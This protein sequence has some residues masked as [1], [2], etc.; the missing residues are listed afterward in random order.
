MNQCAPQRP[1]WRESSAAQCSSMPWSPRRTIDVAGGLDNGT[2]G[3]PG[4]PSAE[5]AC[6]PRQ[7]GGEGAAGVY[8][9]HDVRVGLRPCKRFLSGSRARTA[10]SPLRPVG[11]LRF[12]VDVEPDRYAAV[13]AV[14]SDHASHTRQAGGRDH[15]S[16]L[17]RRARDLARMVGQRAGGHLIS[18]GLNGKKVPVQ[19]LS[20]SA[21]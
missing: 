9:S 21:C 19:S 17:Q 2:L 13:P 1:P 18:G 12:P 11:G 10:R 15:V 16:L 5:L 14:A 4:V 3:T 20:A 7:C 8:P 6:Q